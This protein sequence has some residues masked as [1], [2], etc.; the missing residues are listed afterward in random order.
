MKNQIP[1]LSIY[2]NIFASI[3]PAN[4]IEILT[5]MKI[6][7][8]TNYCNLNSLKRILSDEYPILFEPNSAKPNNAFQFLHSE[9]VNFEDTLLSS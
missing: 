2:H 4:I 3:H 7:Y 9:Y 5:A 6:L 1:N 8:P